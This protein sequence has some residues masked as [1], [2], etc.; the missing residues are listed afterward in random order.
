MVLGFPIL[1]HLGYL[2][3][4]AKTWSTVLITGGMIIR[5]ANTVELQWLEHILDQENLFETGVVR[6]NEG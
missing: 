3:I 1:K 6:A 5:T 2:K 4:V